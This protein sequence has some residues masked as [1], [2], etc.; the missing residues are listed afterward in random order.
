MSVEASEIIT[1]L[2]TSLK[3]HLT[4]LHNQNTNDMQAIVSRVE[5]RIVALQLAV[6]RIEQRLAEIEASRERNV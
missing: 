1:S 5:E 4:D 2:S 6:T 3:Q